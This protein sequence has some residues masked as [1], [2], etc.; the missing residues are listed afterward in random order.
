MALNGETESLTLLSH[1][2]HLRFID[3]A[4]YREVSSAL[5]TRSD[6]AHLLRRAAFGPTRSA[7]DAAVA[8]GFDATL[9][10]R[11]SPF[12]YTTTSRLPSPRSGFLS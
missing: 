4:D 12:T 7:L 10:G 3:P 6:L 1:S 8:S 9:S 2:H 11:S 5:S